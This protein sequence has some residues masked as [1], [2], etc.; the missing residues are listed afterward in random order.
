MAQ[1]QLRALFYVDG[2]NLYHALHDLNQPRLKWLSL[3]AL[4]QKLLPSRSERLLGVVYFSA[5]ASHRAAKNPGQFAR[6]Q[7]YVRALEATSVECVMGRFKMNP[8]KCFTCGSSWQKPEEKETDVA[9]ATHMVR[10]A[11]RNRFDVCYLLSGDT[12]LVPALRIIRAEFPAKELV[13]LS[14]PNRP[15][16]AEILKIA[17]RKVKV[18]PNVVGQC[19]LPATLRAP[20]GTT[21]TRPAEYN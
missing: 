21:I 7:A 18:T 19:L 11:F 5:Y 2:F 1:A 8:V 10:D 17:T 20:D 15:H 14:A 12:D 13:S 16:S 4:A 3:H 9:I 6:H